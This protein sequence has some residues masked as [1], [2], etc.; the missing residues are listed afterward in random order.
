MRTRNWTAGRKKGTPNLKEHHIDFRTL[1]NFSIRDVKKI[2]IEKAT[3]KRYLLLRLKK[4]NGFFYSFENDMNC[5]FD[6]ECHFSSID[7]STM[8][9]LLLSIGL[10]YTQSEIANALHICRRTISSRYSHG[11]KMLVNLPISP[12]QPKF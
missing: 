10:G 5:L 3:L 8:T 6:L 7:K 4:Q 11:I 9:I 2:L 1:N 12:W